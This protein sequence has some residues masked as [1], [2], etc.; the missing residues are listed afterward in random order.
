MKLK[1]LEGFLIHVRT[2]IASASHASLYMYKY[3]NTT[4]A[5]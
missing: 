3:I 5:V 2:A 4:R 1:D